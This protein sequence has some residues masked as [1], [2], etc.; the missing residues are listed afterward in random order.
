MTVPYSGSEA[1]SVVVVVNLRKVD[2]NILSVINLAVSRAQYEAVI[3]YK[4]DLSDYS[5]W[6]NYITASLP[7]VFC[8]YQ[9]IISRR[10]KWQYEW[11]STN[12]KFE[13]CHSIY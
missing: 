2:K 11:N 8:F 10:S 7:K 12:L 1:K 6:K 5:E 3:V 9:D 4:D 13:V